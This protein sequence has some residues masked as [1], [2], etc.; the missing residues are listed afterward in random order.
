MAR[1]TTPRDLNYLQIPIG[2]MLVVGILYLAR[3]V[4]IPLVLAVLITFILMPIVV[5]LQRWGLRRAYGV[6]LTVVLAFSL[7]GI[8]GYVVG[9]Q[10]HSLA[11]ELPKHRTEIETKI[12]SLRQGGG[13]FDNL[14]QMLREIGDDEAHATATPSGQKEII[15]ARQEQSTS[16]EK[17]FQAVSPFLE[18]LAQAG[19]VIVLVIFMLI[20]REDLRNR[21]LGLMGSGRLAGTT[22]V[23]VDSA[24]RLSGYL[25]G[26]S[27]INV[28]FGTLF[29]IGLY[30][31]GV[32]YAILWGFVTAVMR[33]VPFIGTWIA[34]LLPLTL[35]FATSP[36]WTQPVSLVA[37][38]LC[39]D[40]VTANVVEP[41]L[42]GRRTGVSPIALLVAAAF[43]SWLWGPI[44]LILSTPLT[45]CLVVIGQHV[46]QFRF[47]ALLLGDQPPLPPLV[48]Y[49]QRLLARD[50]EEARQVAVEVAQSRGMEKAYDEVLL[51]AL[52]LARQDRKAAGLSAQDEEFILNATRDIVA[53][54]ERDPLVGANPEAMQQLL[55][56]MP[57]SADGAPSSAAAE[58]ESQKRPPIVLLGCPAHQQAEELALRMLA[59]LFKSNGC[60]LDVASTRDLPTEIETRIEQ[61]EPALV[62]IAVVPPGG[63]VQARYLCRRLRRRF[64]ELPIVIGYWGEVGDFDK[65]FRQVRAAGGNY[66]AT[67]LRQARVHIEELTHAAGSEELAPDDRTLQEVTT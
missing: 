24:E 16:I 41:L 62:I 32:E 65:M 23:I 35:S 42:L 8:A 56:K 29:T 50:E 46:P 27:A 31:L 1:S 34:V 7:F 6:L 49:Y 48:R 25:L 3:V 52:T 39:L 36:T 4:I 57:E 47:F 60:R 58:A 2:L 17:I 37:Y 19:F 45:A 38:F 15:V 43:W 55:E 12:A 14:F 26:L 44:G 33:F 20:H 51:P 10:I 67:S 64:P 40:L 54:F 21:F 61:K 9:R 30:F 66:V 13:A 18:P 5:T 63:L 59:S 22:R 28:T 53:E 11:G